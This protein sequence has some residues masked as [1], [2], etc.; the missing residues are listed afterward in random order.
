[1]MRLPVKLLALMLI[2][3]TSASGLDIKPSPTKRKGSDLLFR[4]HRSEGWGFVN[5]AGKVLISPRFEQVGDF[6]RGLARVNVGRK[7]GFINT[8]GEFYIE[9]QFDMAGDFLE[10]LAPVRVGRKWGYINESGQMAVPLQ[11]QGADEFH[12]G[13]ARFEIW[14]TMHCKD[15]KGPKVYTK[16]NAPEYLFEMEDLLFYL[17]SNCQSEDG[18]IGFINSKG[19]ITIRPQFLSAK[20]FSEGLAVVRPNAAPKHGYIN[21]RGEM[22]IPSKFDEA[23]SFSQGLAAF[24]IGLHGQGDWGYIDKTGRVVIQPKF[25]LVGGFSEGLAEATVDGQNWGYINQSGA[26]AIKPKFLRAANFSEGLAAVESEYRRGSLYESYIDQTGKELF[27]VIEN[28]WPFVDGLAVA[29]EEG[30]RVYIDKT[31]K[32]ITP[33]ESFRK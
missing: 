9:P 21:P 32:V 31:G 13:L 27:K 17:S 11:F 10:A 14:T 4:I 23:R 20:S 1:M 19:K 15:E 8:R 7:W 30:R 12:E 16:E 22:V 28:G 29:G 24:R 5:Q 18:R 2:S 25:Q 6:F 26:F 33:F 3:V